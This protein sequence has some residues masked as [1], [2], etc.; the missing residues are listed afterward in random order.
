MIEQTIEEK[1][2]QRRL[3]MLVHS[4]I[5]YE[6]N[7][8]IVDDNTWAKWGK[9]LMDLQEK[10][11]EE[12]AKVEYADQFKDWDASSGAFLSFDKKVKSTATHLLNM[13][14]KQRRRGK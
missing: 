5:Y 14:R 2:R 4:Y 10:Y 6:L 1:I 13:R 12:A 11:P 7:E 8:N 3:Q 9:E